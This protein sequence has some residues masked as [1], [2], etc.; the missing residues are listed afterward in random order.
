M[1]PL[2]Y[3]QKCRWRELI[4]YCRTNVGKSSTFGHSKGSNMNL[5]YAGMCHQHVVAPPD[6][7]PVLGEMFGYET[8]KSFP[9]F[10]RQCSS[11]R[12]VAAQRHPDLTLV[13]N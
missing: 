1:A 3:Q 4:P 7:V 9:G 6:N 13:N 2:K 8:R 11:S 5:H 10:Q 12:A